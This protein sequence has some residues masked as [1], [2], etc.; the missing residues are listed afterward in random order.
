[1]MNDGFGPIA[2]D[3]ASVLILGSMPS[4]ASLQAQE[5]YAHSRNAFW[6]IMGALFG[7][8]GGLGYPQRQQLLLAN[9]IALWDVLRSCYRPGSLD[10]NI[11]MK[12]I[13]INDF[14]GFYTRHPGISRVYFNGGMA[15]KMYRLHVLPALQEHFLHLH[16]QRLLSTSPAYASLT[17]PQK[18]A[19]WEVIKGVVDK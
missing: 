1:M 17:V 19:A 7:G 18:I 11:D 12:S 2:D 16:Y 13:Q 9:H 15:E 8:G 3:K 6:P 14:Y 4:V 5:Y 10:A